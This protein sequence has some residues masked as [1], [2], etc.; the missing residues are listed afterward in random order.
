MKARVVYESMYGNTHEIA[1]RIGEGLRSTYDDLEVVA[2]ADATPSTLSGCELLVV[3]GPTHVHGMTS[4][5]TRDAARQ[6]LTKSPDLVFEPRSTSDGLR[7]W[8]EGLEGGGAAIAFDTRLTGP[9]CF[10]GRASKG[11]ARRLR[12]HG[13]DVI[14]PPVSFLVDKHNHLVEGEAARAV[15]CGRA[16]ADRAAR[17][18][19][20]HTV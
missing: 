7:E 5:R 1:A 8:F 20:S 12:R 3:G 16:V 2:V 13:Y 6:A 17:R 9:A 14:A 4:R 19:D 10:T 15:D 18:A 11:I